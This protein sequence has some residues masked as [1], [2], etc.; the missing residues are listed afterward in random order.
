MKAV[1]AELLTDFEKAAIASQKAWSFACFP[2]MV[3]DVARGREAKPASS[4][5]IVPAPTPDRVPGDCVIVEKES[6][7]AT[8]REQN[9]ARAHLLPLVT[10][11]LNGPPRQVR[12]ARVLAQAVAGEN[13]A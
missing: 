11:I 13:V 7:V 4:I 6:G 12:C 9:R 2:R 5:Q 8:T 1:L 10:P 3:H